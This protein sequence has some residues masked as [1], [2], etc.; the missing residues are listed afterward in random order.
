MRNLY[1]IGFLTFGLT[2][3]SVAVFAITDFSVFEKFRNKSVVE[4]AIEATSI[5]TPTSTPQTLSDFRPD[6]GFEFNSKPS[7]ALKEIT[8]L[9]IITGSPVGYGSACAPSPCTSSTPLVEERV[10]WV[11]QAPH[12]LLVTDNYNYVWKDENLSVEKF[13]FVTETH[14]GQSYQFTG[15]FTS[16]GNYEDTKPKGDALVGRLIKIVDGK[17]VAEE[18]VSFNWF[19]W[20]EVDN[21]TYS[22]KKT[23]SKK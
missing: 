10:N 2:T 20:D 13:S 12:G 18:D 1:R 8:W 19:S 7:K 9:S 17:I 5:I 4:N 22:R 21:E 11:S 23:K 3:L 6:G 16:S 14:K 15:H